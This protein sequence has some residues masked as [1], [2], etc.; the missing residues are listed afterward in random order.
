MLLI[1]VVTFDASLCKAISLNNYENIRPQ[2]FS[3]HRVY[4]PLLVAT[5]PGAICMLWHFISMMISGSAEDLSESGP[6]GFEPKGHLCDV[7]YHRITFVKG[8]CRWSFMD[9]ETEARRSH[10]LI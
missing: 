7:H 6:R 4:T 1:R 3:V 10:K 9:T 5:E 8:A 2:R